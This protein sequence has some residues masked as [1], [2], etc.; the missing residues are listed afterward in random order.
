[1]ELDPFL[2]GSASSCCVWQLR[3]ACTFSY[4]FLGYGFGAD[5]LQQIELCIASRK[6]SFQLCHAIEPEQNRPLVYPR[7]RPQFNIIVDLIGMLPGNV[8]T[9]I[10]KTTWR[11][12]TLL[13][14]S[15]ALCYTATDPP[16][17]RGA[18]EFCR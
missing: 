13:T 12:F 17:P 1:M 14:G 11:I 16:L 4:R 3:L 5:I 9:D 15:A 2:N 7:Q 10:Q 18:Y 6:K 8:K